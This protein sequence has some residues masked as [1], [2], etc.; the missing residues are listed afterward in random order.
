MERDSPQARFA[1]EAN[2]KSNAV[3]LGSRSMVAAEFA[4]SFSVA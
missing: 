2:V 3:K 1:C 4:E